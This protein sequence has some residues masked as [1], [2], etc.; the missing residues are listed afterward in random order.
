MRQLLSASFIFFSLVCVPVSS[1][2]QGFSNGAG[3]GTG[4]V[5][6]LVDDTDD[7]D[8]LQSGEEE[9]EVDVAADVEPAGDEEELFESASS[10][11][12]PEPDEGSE[13]VAPALPE[14]SANGNLSYQYEVPVPAWRGLEP[15]IALTYDSARKTK[16]SGLYQSW[17]GHGWGM[18]GFD[19]I[20]R[21]RPKGGVAAFDDNDIFVL[22]GMEMLA[23][24]P[25]I[26]S[27]SCSHGGTHTTEYESF[28]RIKYLDVSN[29]WEVTDRDGTVSTFQSYETI[30]GMTH[31]GTIEQEDTFTRYVWRL[32]S[33]EDTNGNQVNY[34][35]VC[36]GPGTCRPDQVTYGLYSVKFHWE[37]RPDGIVMA[38]G[39]TMEEHYHRVKT[40]EAKVDGSAHAA[41]AIS[42]QQEAY[43]QNSQLTQLLRYGTDAVL[44]V[45]GAVTAGTARPPVTFEYIGIDTGFDEEIV[46]PNTRM[47]KSFLFQAVDFN[48][49]GQD[50]LVWWGT[51]YAKRSSTSS[52]LEGGV[53]PSG[54]FDDGGDGG[55]GGGASYPTGDPELLAHSFERDESREWDF[56]YWKNGT[57]FSSVGR[58]ST[59]NQSS[60]VFGF[61]KQESDGNGNFGEFNVLYLENGVFEEHACS[62]SSFPTNHGSVCA[63]VES[64]TNKDKANGD[65]Q[66]NVVSADR[67]RTGTDELINIY[68]EYKNEHGGKPR[69][70]LGVADFI[71][72]GTLSSY[73]NVNAGN[74]PKT[75]FNVQ[76]H[77]RARHNNW[78]VTYVADVNGDGLADII[79]VPYFPNTGTFG[80]NV[81]VRFFTGKKFEKLSSSQSMSATGYAREGGKP[82]IALLDVNGDG[83]VDF[84]VGSDADVR[85]RAFLVHFDRPGG[86][87]LDRADEIKWSPTNTSDLTIGDF[88][89]DGIGDVA[90]VRGASADNKRIKIFHSRYTSGTPGLMKSFTSELGGM[91]K[92][93]YK[94][95]TQS[96]HHHMPFASSVVSAIEVDDGRTSPVTTELE[97]SGGKYDHPERKFLGFETQVK[98]LPAI[99]GEGGNGPEITTTFLQDVP[100]YGRV[101][102]EVRRDGI[103]TAL[104]ERH[105]TWETRGQSPPYLSFNTQTLTTQHES[106][107]SVSRAIRRDFDQYG[108][109]TYEI[110]DG[111]TDLTGDESRTS[112]FYSRLNTGNYIVNLPSEVRQNRGTGNALDATLLSQTHY[113]YDGWVGGLD[114]VPTIGNLT[115]VTQTNNAG[116]GNAVTQFTYDS[117]GN[118]IAQIDPQGNRTEWTYDQTHQQFVI[119]E[120]NALYFGG[121]TR[122]QT[123]QTWNNVCQKPATQTDL[124][125]TTS[126]WDYDVFCRKYNKWRTGDGYTDLWRYNHEGNPASQNIVHYKRRGSQS[127]WGHTITYLD[128]LARTYKTLGIRRADGLGPIYT[129][130]NFDDR[131]NV[132]SVSHPKFSTDGAFQFTTTD[133]DG[134][135]RPINITHPDGAAQRIEY[136]KPG[137]LAAD[138]GVPF[139]QVDTYD[140]LD[141]RTMQ[142]ADARGNI[143]RIIRYGDGGLRNEFRSFDTL[144]RLTGVKDHGGNEWSYV[145]DLAGNR[146]A[147]SDPDLGYWTYTHDRNGNLLSQ[148]D[149]R[150]ETTQL[151]YDGLNRLLTRTDQ[152]SGTVHAQNTYDEARIGHHNVGQLTSATNAHGTHAYD[153]DRRGNLARKITSVDGISYV[154]ETNWDR[155]GV[156]AWRKYY[157]HPDNDPNTLTNLRQIGFNN[158]PWRYDLAGNLIAIPGLIDHIDYE[159]NG[160][161][162]QIR[163]FNGVITDFSYDAQRRWLTRVHTHGPNGTLQDVF[164]T[165][166]PTGRIDAVHGEGYSDSGQTNYTS[167]SGL[168]DKWLYTYN[169]YDELIVADNLIDNA[170]DQTFGYDNLGNIVTNS[171]LGL[172]SYPAPGLGALRPHA[173][174]RISGPQGIRDFTYDANG[175]MVTD[176]TRTLVWDA[177]NKLS[178][179][180]PLGGGQAVTFQYGPDGSRIAKLSSF[181][182]KRIYA[183]ADFEIAPDGTFILYPHADVKIEGLQTTWLHRD[184]LNSVR[185][186]S[187]DNGQAIEK[188]VYAPF[189]ERTSDGSTPS[190]AATKGYIGERHDPETGL[191]YLNARYHDPSIGRFISPDDWDPTIEGVGTNRYAYSANDPVNKSDPNGHIFSSRHGGSIFGKDDSD[192]DEDDTQDDSSSETG[193][194]PAAASDGEESLEEKKKKGDGTVHLVAGDDFKPITLH[195]PNAWLEDLVA[196]SG[197]GGSKGA[198]FSNKHPKNIAAFE[199]S[200]KDAGLPQTPVKSPTSGNIVGTQYTLPNGNK[201]RVMQ[202]D[203]RNEPRASFTNNNGQPI[204][205]RTGK[206]PQPPRG[207]S[208]QER[209]SYVRSRTHIVFED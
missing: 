171:K 36:D 125:G 130:Y 45:D 52:F 177:Q 17:L 164:Y 103:G 160:D 7:V 49:N 104:V 126:L 131:G 109:P 65:L 189:G 203:G 22:N 193:E 26:V 169:D 174:T 95:S 117:V 112:T 182:G 133:Y 184:H 176:G 135:D 147:T 192:D 29:S 152:A 40:I 121:D 106:N 143:T 127:G 149:A 168:K 156:V 110:D 201:V 44:D 159:A 206:P 27:P 97:F 172:Y 8:G 3:S 99:E 35:Y 114:D 61:R 80:F 120:R 154:S 132:R 85:R 71:G 129:L 94:P 118:R 105:E 87:D 16:R 178:S 155:A 63:S 148:T 108:N 23:C 64:L 76:G 34:A 124:N 157:Q 57:D 209:K 200:L 136:S 128:G 123:S 20:T 102:S 4:F 54:R 19:V 141:R 91:T 50:E 162:R 89:G 84:V 153:Y 28:R 163:Y 113:A 14:A 59:P 58:Y 68:E 83:R 1:F 74:L 180:T 39:Q 75:N 137:I 116:Q 144:G 66:D 196:S 150:G 207:L 78:D 81:K 18:T 183:D 199:K 11:P 56:G 10:T 15:R 98:K 161:T 67:N 60:F 46:F 181:T 197:G 142:V 73:Y 205:P 82:D 55:G 100:N 38:N 191:I 190:S 167:H 185:V 6:E 96:E 166:G 77:T 101:A 170:L 25:D 72:D 12:L 70:R 151:T 107:G 62:A 33:V 115:R 204:D 37:G 30:S 92:I 41:V 2:A 32:T 175:N 138:I 53:A 145:Y 93:A 42:Y 186:V 31:D 122:Q 165:R 146:I 21:G 139:S 198:I 43:S 88:N 158:T 47:Q 86:A 134:L 24:T 79:E 48:Q 194:S 208:T 188:S 119:A 111:R 179:V 5:D 90:S 173:Q 51:P 140:E 202:A 69:Y 195:A 9:P 187:D 13:T